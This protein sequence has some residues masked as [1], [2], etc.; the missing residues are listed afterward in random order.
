MSGFA[1]WSYGGSAEPTEQ[2]RCNLQAKV[3]TSLY[4]FIVVDSSGRR[5]PG[6]IAYIRCAGCS[7]ALVDRSRAPLHSARL[8]PRAGRACGRG[9]ERR[10]PCAQARR[11]AS[12]LRFSPAVRAEAGS[13]AV[14]PGRSDSP[15]HDRVSELE[16]RGYVPQSLDCLPGASNGERTVAKDPTEDRL[17]DIHALDLRHVDFCRVPLH[18]PRL[19]DNPTVGDRDLSAEPLEPCRYEQQ[20]ASDST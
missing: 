3:E 19:V 12:R 6:G 13:S 14:S 17:A 4:S 2:R 20:D 18:Q 7:T 8:P 1:G 5:L 16:G 9:G 15:H 10:S 11:P